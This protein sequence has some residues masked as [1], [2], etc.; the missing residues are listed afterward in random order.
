MKNE[1]V[2]K[3]NILINASYNLELTEQRL[4]L[5]S[6][7]R[8]RETGQGITADSKLQIYAGDYMYHYK[9]DR[10]AAYKAL[11][12][13]ALNLFERQFSFKEEH[14]NTGKMGT[15]KSR[16]VSRIKYIDELAIL[17][18]TFSP[19]VVPLIT[20]LEKHFTSY[21]LKQVSQL[22]SKYAI[23]LYEILIAWR[24][25][26]KTPVINLADF[27]AQL[28]LEVTEYTAMNN[29]KK[30]VLE[31][32][33][34]QIN[35]LTD[36]TVEYDQFKDGR[37]ISGIQFKLKLKSIPISCD[38]RK[39]KNTPDLFNGLTEKQINLFAKKLAY[40]D[41]FASRY[42]EA[43]ENYFELEVRLINNLSDSGFIS[44]NMHHL[45]RLGL[46]M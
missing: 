33:L 43:G 26:G 25:I 38:E 30:R 27:R 35:K 46:K 5:L 3:D 1:L 32:A 21:K 10:H 16:W 22:T 13:A 37:V 29:F 42:A 23:R 45:E 41:E 9:V 34:D 6:I 2:V 40:D 8:A 15:V 24:E 36:I 39:D 31:P 28:G 11:K 44:D 20:R 4:I 17:E 12:E 19:D 14:E 18:V 7:V